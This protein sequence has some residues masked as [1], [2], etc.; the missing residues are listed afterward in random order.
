[1]NTT[2]NHCGFAIFSICICWEGDPLFFFWEKFTWPF[3]N[4][5][6]STH[7]LYWICWVAQE[8][9][10]EFLLQKWYN[11]LG[12]LTSIKWSEVAQSCLTL[13]DP[14]DCNLPGS[15]VQGILQAR[16]LEW[17]A[18]SFFRG[19]SWPRDRTRVSGIA[20][21]CFILWATRSTMNTI[22]VL[23]HSFTWP[24]C[25]HFLTPSW[26]FFPQD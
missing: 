5:Y 22:E 14:V 3:T 8:I 20:G 11:Y 7:V 1:M 12:D 13:C 10:L 19:S 18:I 9:P 26:I 21:R 17:A 2:Y 25:L 6:S 24:V 16:T 4:L 15:S 23:L